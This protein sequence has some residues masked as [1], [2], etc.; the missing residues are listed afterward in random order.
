MSSSLRQRLTPPGLMGRVASTTSFI[1][2]GGNCL[3]ALLGGVVAASFGLTAPY[4]VS[5][6]V[7]ALVTALTRRVFN[8][9]T[10]AQAYAEPA[11]S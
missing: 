4:W 2:A 11:P 1:A 7:A 10:V 5:F 6:A 8:R 9:A 3:G